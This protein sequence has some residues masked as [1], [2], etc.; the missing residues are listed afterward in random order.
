[1]KR[2]FV[3]RLR[4]DVELL[5]V[6]LFCGAGGVSSGVIRAKISGCRVAKVLYCVNHDENAIKSH[7]ANHKRIK[8]SVEDIRTMDLKDLI[9]TVKHWRAIYPNA[10]VVLWAS[11]ECTHFSKARGGLARDADSRT[12]A[13]SLFRYIEA[14]DPD[15]IQIENVIE[16]MS[17]GPMRIRG[18]KQYANYTELSWIQNKKTKEWSYGWQPISKLKGDDYVKWKEM[19]QSYGYD[20]QHRVINCADLGAYTSRKRY[21]GQFAKPGLPMV[22][23]V[24]THYKKPKP[25]Q[26][27]W[28]A[29]RRVLDLHDH[30]VSIFERKTQLVDAT[31]ERVYAGLIK[32]VAKGE[33]NFISKTFSG[34]PM[35]KVNST[36]DPCATVTCFGGP[37]IVTP[38]KVDNFLTLYYSNGGETGSTGEPCPTLPTKDRISIATPVWIDEGYTKFSHKAVSSPCGAITVNAGKMNIVTPEPIIL[39]MA[40]NNAA[41]S[42]NDPLKTI[43]ADRRWFHIMNPQYKNKPRSV[44]DPCPTIIAQQGKAP[45]HLMVTEEG[46]M[47]IQVFD[48]DTPIMIKIKEFMAAYGIR[49]IKMRMLNIRELK[50]ITGFR[51]N[52]ILC[53][54]QSDQKKFIGNAVPVIVAKSWAEE[55][56]AA[57]REQR[58]LLIAA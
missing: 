14:I 31:F 9:K 22:F 46:E 2:R 13:Y 52:Y 1:M 54:T 3:N 37:N 40:Y 21:F 57:L 47:M 28:K 6:D 11:L 42:V 38:E 19:V 8:H 35:G 56:A 33:E 5:Y 24:Q 30:G 44:E 32:Y 48:T 50:L 23:P 39:D 15:Y 27:K 18:K 20:F 53:G 43:T 51:A 36:K 12:L 49:D 7:K 10:K 29:V 17:W 25:G 34:R 55:I 26:K 45:L 16:F 41:S 58:E 4:G